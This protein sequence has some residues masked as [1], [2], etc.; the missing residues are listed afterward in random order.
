MK[1]TK[2]LRENRRVLF[3]AGGMA[4]LGLNAVKSIDEW[5]DREYFGEV[6][7]Q[8]YYINSPR[9]T[10]TDEEIGPCII[11]VQNPSSLSV[12]EFNC[13]PACSSLYQNKHYQSCLV[14]DDG[15]ADKTEIRNEGKYNALLDRILRDMLK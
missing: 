8:P 9:T 5:N 11:R 4:I 3:L 1:I 7:G 6:Y 15:N 14:N 2:I 12:L 10:L 13:Y